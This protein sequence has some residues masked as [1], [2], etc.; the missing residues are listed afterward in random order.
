M[1]FEVKQYLDSGII[2]QYC[3]EALSLEQMLEVE[4]VAALYPEIKK[5]ILSCQD[6][7]EKF[8]KSIEKHPPVD[9]KSKLFDSIHNLDLEEIISKENLP[10]LNKYS[11]STS[12]L[13]FAKSLLPSETKE[14]IYLDV[15]RNDS[16]VYLSIIWT[17]TNIPN[18][19]HEN[20][21]ESFLILEGECECLVGD[22]R[23]ILGPGDFF[24]VPMH[25]DHNV[26]LLSPK[27][28]AILQHVAA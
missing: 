13:T 28:L 22:K 16:E 9:V 6:T 8:A 18:E 1:K 15:L 17:K 7:M 20:E 24:E 2:E 14:D 25:T 27:V 5:A 26:N 21:K 11:K 19:V 3:F 10:M 4:L 23:Y 12:W